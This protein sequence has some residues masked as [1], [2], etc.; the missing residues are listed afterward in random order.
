MIFIA[1]SLFCNKMWTIDSAKESL[2][3]VGK[4]VAV[5]LL[6]VSV[7][8]GKFTSVFSDVVTVVACETLTFWAGPDKP[9]A[10][11]GTLFGRIKGAGFGRIS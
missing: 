3:A 2:S 5:L 1:S 8:W 4:I 10:E 9:S 6:V 7:F 11:L